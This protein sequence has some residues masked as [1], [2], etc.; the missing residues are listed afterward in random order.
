MFAQAAF[1][2]E[3]ESG[4]IPDNIIFEETFSGMVFRLFNDLNKPS[5]HGKDYSS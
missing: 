4:F 5:N 3:Q 2:S 1:P